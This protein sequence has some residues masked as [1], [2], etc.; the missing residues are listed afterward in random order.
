MRRPALRWVAL[1][2]V[3]GVAGANVRI[4][5]GRTWDDV[6]YHTEISPPRLAAAD[7]VQH[8]SLPAWWEGTGLGVPLAGEPSH[9]AMY[10]PAW[11]AA[12]PRALDWMAMV[13]LMWLAIGVAV[14]ARYRS[15]RPA[16][17]RIWAG[18]ASEP[19]S[20]VVALLV[21]TSGLATSA[22]LRGALPALA[23]LPWIGVAACWLA[24]AE[25]RATRARAAA[26]LGLAIGMVGLAGNLAALVD[27]LLVAGVLVVRSTPRTRTSETA[28]SASS[29]P[30]AI[31][32]IAALAGG[33][34]IAAAQWLP[35]LLHLGTP[36]AGA[37]VT[38][39]PLARLI[40]LVVPTASG[41]PNPERAIA[42]LAGDRPWAPSLFVGAP[43][44]ALAAVRVP[45]RRVLAIAGVLAVLTLTA[46]RG[47][48]PAWLGAPEVHLAAL[49]IVLGAHAGSGVDALVGS[50]RRAILA[51]AAGVGCAVISLISIA[52]ARSRTELSGAFEAG[53]ING[54]LGVACGIGAIAIAYRGMQRA[55]P[56]VFALLVIPSFG[57]GP[58]IA[59]TIDRGIVAQQPAW[60][61]AVLATKPSS[62]VPR[63]PS[64]APL[65]TPSVSP[66]LDASILAAPRRV[67]RRD[68]LVES[69][70]ERTTVTT[71]TN[72]PAAEPAEHESLAD[73]IETFAGTSAARW[74][75]GAGRSDDPARHVDH[76]ATWLAAAS[77]GGRL[78]DRFG[79]GLAVL[80]ETLVAP[81]GFTALSRRGRW[82]IVALPVAPPASVMRSWVRAVEPSNAFSLLFPFEDSLT[83]P[84]GAVVLGEPGDSQP[85]KPKDSPVPCA[86]EDWSAGN[87]ELSCTSDARGYAVVSSCAAVGWSVTVDGADAH[88]T[89]ADVLRRA[90]AVPAGTHRVHWSY[91]APGLN[92]GLAIAGIGLALLIALALASRR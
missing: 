25:T 6:R 45:S 85:P 21:A 92:L 33:L 41:S 89:T 57:A 9:G 63:D 72:K 56:A 14:W 18:H 2:L 68:S 36:H 73:A 55:I 51:L 4:L 58:G 67:Y 66:V 32:V 75:I 37:E 64:G 53:L 43:L 20:I 61:E 52:V 69:F 27:A 28:S 22:A 48:W 60:A 83:L 31:Y 12:S 84:R 1:V 5:F 7:T 50:E 78:L 86:I 8:G 71:P 23:H 24:E 88:W 17:L 70:G 10:P 62:I 39:L 46:G 90:V 65:A 49:A 34:A 87:V 77:N 30:F 13:H 42:M 82:A 74:G 19:S 26:A 3:L 47:G 35:A 15:E 16:R 59:P 11:I 38:G 54:G 80:P 91:A 29:G 79:I 40:E 76:D 44:L 81:R